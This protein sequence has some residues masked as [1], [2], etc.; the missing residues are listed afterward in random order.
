VTFDPTPA[1][2]GQSG[3]LSQFTKYIDWMQLSWNEWVINYDFS[4]Q[5]QM[6]QNLQRSSRDWTQSWRAWFEHAQIYN[7]QRLKSLQLRHGTL[8]LLLP[9]LLI[10]MLVALRYEWLGKLIRRLRLYW[11]LHTPESQRANPVLASRLYAELLRVLERR[12][13]ARRPADTP[14]E[15]ASQVQT[16]TLGSAV[17]EFTNIYAVARYG[18]AP[19]DTMRLR[20]LLEQVRAA[21]RQR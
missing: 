10:L 9:L 8:G 20:H 13:F 1:G 12:G 7:R 6:A 16:P 5:V 19:C 21:P 14:M 17:R 15:F 2:S 11:Q 4:H 3:F 18:G